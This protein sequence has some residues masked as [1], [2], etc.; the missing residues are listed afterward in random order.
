MKI[1]RLEMLFAR[2]HDHKADQEQDDQRKDAEAAPP[3]PAADEGVEERPEHGG[4]LAEDIEEPV[5]LVAA[6]LR[7]QLAEIAAADG[8]NAALDGADQHG[9]GPEQDRREG[10]SLPEAAD[11]LRA[12]A[13]EVCEGEGNALHLRGGSFGQRFGN[14]LIR[15]FLRFRIGEVILQAVAQGNGLFIRQILQRF[16]I[17]RFQRSL[18]FFLMGLEGETHVETDHADQ[19]IDQ[20]G[21]DQR[22]AG[23]EF[24]RQVRE[25]DRAGHGHDLRDKEGQDHSDG[26]QA[27][28]G[29]V[30][31]IHGGTINNARFIPCQGNV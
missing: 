4:E 20:D 19:G 1:Q 17:L 31:T 24:I 21:A 3:G 16:G 15:L 27:Q 7:D 29:A 11:F 12:A 23:G 18:V 25:D 26:A 30:V 13:D 8:L 10:D 6:L 9:H 2:D 14:G 22:P 5:E 28:R